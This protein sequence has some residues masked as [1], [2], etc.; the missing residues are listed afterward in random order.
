ME[1]APGTGTLDLNRI[2]EEAIAE[3]GYVLNSE[4]EIKLEVKEGH[5]HNW[6][7]IS[8]LG[9]KTKKR[10]PHEKNNKSGEGE[11]LKNEHSGLLSHILLSQLSPAEKSVSEEGGHTVFTKWSQ[12]F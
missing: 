12:I 11:V 7:H 8:S 2:F 3:P 4:E 9:R 1:L 5:K 10:V 6:G